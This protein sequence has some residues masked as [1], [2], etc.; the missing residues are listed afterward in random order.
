MSHTG[1]DGA[2]DFAVDWGLAS[3]RKTLAGKIDADV[4]DAAP[5]SLRVDRIDGVMEPP[6]RGRIEPMQ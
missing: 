3:D 4:I 6:P 2:C 5:G 1:S